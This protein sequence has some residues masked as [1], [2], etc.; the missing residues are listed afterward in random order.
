M[1]ALI[2][3][4][5]AWL[6][7]EK[8]KNDPFATYGFLTGDTGI[9]LVQACLGDPEELAEQI[10][11]IVDANRDNPAREFMWGSP[12][13]MLASLWLYD[14]TGKQIWVDRFRRDAAILW[15]RLEFFDAAAV[16]F[17]PRISSATKRYISG[18]CMALQATHFRYSGVGGSSRRMNNPD[19]PSDWRNR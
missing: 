14:H 10:G 1:T 16:S 7:G 4:N 8:A 19:G 17:G 18:L 6:Y 9:L 2:A 15:K 11:S 3:S 12:G 13:T 5:R